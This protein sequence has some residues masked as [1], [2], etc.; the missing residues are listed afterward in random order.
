MDLINVFKLKRLF[1]F[2]HLLLVV[3]VDSWS[4]VLLTLN[5]C[6]P[7]LQ[8]I[9]QHDQLLISRGRKTTVRVDL[10]QPIYLHTL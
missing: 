4:L 9:R 8:I 10:R 1:I 6:Y 2:T 5:L 7:L 3:C